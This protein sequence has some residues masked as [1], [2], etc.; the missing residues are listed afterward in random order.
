M[1]NQFLKPLFGITFLLASVITA[2]NSNNNRQNE[3]ADTVDNTDVYIDSPMTRTDTLMTDTV[4]S[5]L[6]R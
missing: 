1:K 5:E 4:G 2:C 6:P 3:Y